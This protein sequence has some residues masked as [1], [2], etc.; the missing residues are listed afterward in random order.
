MFMNSIRYAAAIALTLAL[1]TPAF[2]A[3]TAKAVLKEVQAESKKWQADAVL[4]HVSTL[5]GRADGTARSWLYTVYS[6]KMK[7]S[8]I[9]TA[10]DAKV[11]VDEVDRNTSTSPLAD[12]FLDSDKVAE[13]ARKAGLKLEADSIGF[14]LTTFGTATAKPTVAW[15]VTGTNRE[16]H[17]LHRGGARGEVRFHESHLPS[18]HPGGEDP[19][20]Q[21]RRPLVRDGG[22]LPRVP[23]DAGEDLEAPEVDKDHAEAGRKA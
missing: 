2:A 17:R 3:S 18:L 1:A 13:A 7:K 23:G 22:G 20:E 11:E 19:G 12:D 9:I 4:T 15:T 8:A 21:G 16:R 14:G 10:R 5:M 6:P